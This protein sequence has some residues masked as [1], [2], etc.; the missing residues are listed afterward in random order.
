[1]RYNLLKKHSTKAERIV[2]EEL[3]RLHISFKHRWIINGRE[4][5]FVLADRIVLEIDGHPQ[6]NSEKNEMLIKA[7]YTPI[8]L[9]NKDVIKKRDKLK[10][11]LRIYS[12]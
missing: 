7:G 9:R 1:M 10:L 12:I 8:H 3:K 11:W 2:Y 6:L 5:D 4:V